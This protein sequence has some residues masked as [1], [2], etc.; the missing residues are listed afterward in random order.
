MGSPSGRWGA[1]GAGAERT[2]FNVDVQ[3][4]EVPGSWPVVPAALHLRVLSCSPFAGPV[5]TGHGGA[6]T[7]YPGRL[8]V[9]LGVYGRGVGGLFAGA[10]TPCALSE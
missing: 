5:C 3:G 10:G 1:P 7:V 4:R 6:C 8:W 2:W 9:L